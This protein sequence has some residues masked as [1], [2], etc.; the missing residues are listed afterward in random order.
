M[1]P[2]IKLCS[3]K[4]QFLPIRRDGGS[5][6][7]TRLKEDEELKKSRLKSIRD[8]DEGLCWRRLRDKDGPVVVLVVLVLLNSILIYEEVEKN[9]LD[10]K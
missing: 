4:I 10:E 2:Y 6:P 5:W 1:C 3:I 8:H 9:F 7:S